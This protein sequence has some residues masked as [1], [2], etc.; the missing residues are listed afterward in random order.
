MG[1]VGHFWSLDVEE[2]FYLVWPALMLLTPKKYIIYVIS[3]AFLIGYLF[4]PMAAIAGM[5]SKSFYVL[6]FPHMDTLSAG[7][8]LAWMTRE[9]KLKYFSKGAHKF[10]I[11]VSFICF[12]VSYFSSQ[13]LNSY[14]LNIKNTELMYTSL[15]VLTFVVVSYLKNFE[16]SK[17]KSFL[18]LAPLAWLGKVSYAFYLFHNIVPEIFIG[19]RFTPVDTHSIFSILVWSATSIVLAGASWYIIEKPILSHK[20]R[21]ERFF[22]HIFRSRKEATLM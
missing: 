18:E 9:N 5:S 2:Q 17:L 10:I 13:I 15:L 22:F 1:Y 4:Y 19:T 7:A 21:A 3:G 20:S 6:P 16:S 8:I 11:Y 12:S 14:G